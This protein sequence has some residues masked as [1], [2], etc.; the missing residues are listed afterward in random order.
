MWQRELMR[1]IIN[2]LNNSKEEKFEIRWAKSKNLDRSPL[3][4]GHLSWELRWDQPVL[5]MWGW[6]DRGGVKGWA[7]RENCDQNV[8]GLVLKDLED[9]C[10]WNKSHGK[11]NYKE[12]QVYSSAWAAI[13]KY[14]RMGS[15][16]SRNLV[17]Y[18]SGG[19]K[20]KTKVPAR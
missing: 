15:L 5:E 11:W 3:L 6:S 19:S 14:H 13:M 20:S 9:Q 2:R 7:C 8:L 1:C 10:N 17:F 4:E 16:N 12:R 18:S